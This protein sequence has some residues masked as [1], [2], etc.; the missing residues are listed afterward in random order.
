MH[1]RENVGVVIVKSP[2]IW[3]RR[4]IGFLGDDDVGVCVRR[5]QLLPLRLFSRW[6]AAHTYALH[7][8][9]SPTRTRILGVGD[10]IGVDLCVLLVASGLSW[11][12]WR[13]ARSHWRSLRAARVC[14]PG[15]G[16]RAGGGLHIIMG[17]VVHGPVGLGGC[18]V[19]VPNSWVSP[20]T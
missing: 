16:P 11:I 6:R 9:T 1:S 20:P 17:V 12:G 4:V 18:D 19:R 14:C 3:I 10:R 7:A 13:V 2:Y 15:G 5:R 8:H